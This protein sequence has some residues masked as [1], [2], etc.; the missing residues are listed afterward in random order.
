MVSWPVDPANLIKLVAWA[1]NKNF[2]LLKSIIRSQ[3]LVYRPLMVAKA[4]N[5]LFNSSV[6]LMRYMLN[7]A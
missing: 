6:L 2:D 3:T 7:V 1:W 5:T 4:I